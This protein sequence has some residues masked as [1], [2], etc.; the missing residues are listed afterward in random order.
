M[1]SYAHFIAF[2]AIM[3]KGLCKKAPIVVHRP[4]ARAGYT[5]DVP[6]LEDL[7]TPTMEDFP[8][9]EVLE[10]PPTEVPSSPEGSS[11]GGFQ[12]W[13]IGPIAG[14]VVVFAVAGN[15]ALLGGYNAAYSG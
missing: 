1:S 4:P 15:S 7:V 3:W 5:V 9:P 8:P 10:R 11:A 6:P 2:S 12:A 14:G 13:W